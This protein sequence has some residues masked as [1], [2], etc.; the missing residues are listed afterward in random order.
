[1]NRPPLMTSFEVINPP[2]APTTW[3][4]VL[5]AIAQRVPL[6]LPLR[7]SDGR[8]FTLPVSDLRLEHD[9]HGFFGLSGQTELG[10]ING[11]LNAKTIDQPIGKITVALKENH[12]RD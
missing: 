9:P 4:L 1:M 2:D 10:S 11:H 12:D 7:G 8:E 5:L 3:N 6:D